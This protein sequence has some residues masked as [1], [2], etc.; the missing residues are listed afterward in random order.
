VSPNGDT[1]QYL[2][3]LSLIEALPR[4][5]K[6][7]PTKIAK[8]R[9]CMVHPPPASPPSKLP[10]GLPSVLLISPCASCTVLLDRSNS[11]SCKHSSA[12]VGWACKTFSGRATHPQGVQHIPRAQPWA[13]NEA[14]PYLRRR[15]LQEAGASN[16]KTHHK[17]GR[18][19]TH[20]CTYTSLVLLFPWALTR[21]RAAG[22]TCK[23]Y[24]ARLQQQ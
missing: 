13:G 10:R 17:N 18:H 5:Q 24:T 9:A 11:M 16:R 19:C 8:M 15:G 7:K 22:D 23:P 3:T 4:T 2:K 20:T 1:P 6:H 21:R 12:L 14:C